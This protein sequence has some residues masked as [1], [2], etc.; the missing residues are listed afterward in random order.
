MCV[1]SREICKKHCITTVG[2]TNL[3]HIYI[4]AK[5]ISV[6]NNLPTTMTYL[7]LVSDIVLVNTNGTP[8]LINMA[9]PLDLSPW[10]EWYTWSIHSLLSFECSLFQRCVSCRNIMS[11]PKVCKCGKIL[12]HFMGWC[13]P[14][15]FQVEMHWANRWCIRPSHV[16]DNL[17]MSSLQHW[18][19]ERGKG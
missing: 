19:G 7:S 13:I 10:L 5:T 1:G 11:D 17:N 18:E 12:L 15:T 2:H 6:P 16:L 3:D 8:F 9:V 14:L 4:L